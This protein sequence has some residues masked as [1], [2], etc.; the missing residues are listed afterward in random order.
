MF[1][2]IEHEG[3]LIAIIIHKDYHQNGISFIT[4]NDFSLQMGYMNRPA[5]YRIQPHI[6]NPVKRETVGTQEV[7]FIKSGRIEVDLF[8]FEQK[9]LQS[10][11]LSAGDFILLVG[12]GHGQKQAGMAGLVSDQ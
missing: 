10:R 7:L 5:G 11:S 3:N 4:P 1:E 6:H 8:S 9:Y 2:K 12:A